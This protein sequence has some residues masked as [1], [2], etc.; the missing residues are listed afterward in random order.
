MLASARQAFLENLAVAAPARL[1]EAARR[2]A[3]GAVEG[4]HEIRQVAR[5]PTSQRDV[6]DR[7]VVVG[8]QRGRR[9]AAASARRY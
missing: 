9:V 1:A 5:S 3:G 4:T 6:G 8:Q 2:D 7:P